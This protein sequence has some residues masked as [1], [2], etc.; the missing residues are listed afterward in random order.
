MY[1]GSPFL[2]SLNYKG[3]FF[4]N[5]V[6]R[7]GLLKAP[8]SLVNT[9][10]YLQVSMR[11]HGKWPNLVMLIQY[12]PLPHI[13]MSTE[14]EHCNHLEIYCHEIWGWSLVETVS[15]SHV[16]YRV[17]ILHIHRTKHRKIHFWIFYR[18]PSVNYWNWE[19]LKPAKRKLQ[20]RSGKLWP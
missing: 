14:G 12:F 15:Q 16:M 19:L 1:K 2:C 8:K 5:V 11:P 10:K 18:R 13:Q 6:I 20:R 3:N 4:N 17:N 7:F 9:L